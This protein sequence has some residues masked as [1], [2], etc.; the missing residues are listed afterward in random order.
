MNENDTDIGDND[1][2]ILALRLTTTDKHQV[3]QDYLMRT[4]R[5]FI[6]FSMSAIAVMLLS[7]SLTSSNNVSALTIVARSLEEDS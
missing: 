5:A 3:Q 7:L 2:A 6:R 4:C 1:A